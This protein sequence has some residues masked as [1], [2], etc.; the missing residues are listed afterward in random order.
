MFLVLLVIGLLSQ[1]AWWLVLSYESASS[2][3]EHSV[4]MVFVR[5]PLQAREVHK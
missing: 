2:E 4:N 5:A 3:V 1:V